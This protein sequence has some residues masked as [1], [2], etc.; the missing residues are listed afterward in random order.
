MALFRG[1]VVPGFRAK[2]R[3]QFNTLLPGFLNYP[4]WT[5]ALQY[6]HLPLMEPPEPSS[7][8]VFGVGEKEDP[9]PQ[10]CIKLRDRQQNSVTIFFVKPFTTSCGLQ[11]ER[12]KVGYNLLPQANKQTVKEVSCFQ[13]CPSVLVLLRE[14]VP[15]LGGLLEGRG[16]SATSCLAGDARFV[17]AVL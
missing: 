11:T 1:L 12:Q 3:L 13:I 5:R 15:R 17:Q 9:K 10:H 7:G 14:A 4:L 8:F 2:L 6:C 16:A